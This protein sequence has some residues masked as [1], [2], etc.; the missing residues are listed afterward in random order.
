MGGKKYCSTIRG[1]I[2][3]SRHVVQCMFL[4]IRHNNDCTGIKQQEVN[5]NLMGTATI[6]TL[7]SCGQNYSWK[8]LEL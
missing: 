3:G 7:Q 1:F 5:L 2:I 6:F 4:A 8:H